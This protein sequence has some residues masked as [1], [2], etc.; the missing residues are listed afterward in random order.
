MI[1]RYTRPE[2]KEI[3]SEQ[4]KFQQ[5]LNV[6]IAVVNAWEARGVIPKT[7][8]ETI[9]KRANFSLERINEIEAEVH[10]DVI[11]FTTSVAEYVGESSRYF[12]YGLTS[13]DVV[14][15]A[16]AL[17]LKQA[18]EQILGDLDGL[19]EVCKEQAIRYKD[20]VMIGRTHGVH[21]EPITFGLKLALWYE[22]MKRNR[23][24]LLSAIKT[25]SYG[26]ISGAVGTYANIEPEIEKEVCLE[27]GLRPANISTQVLQRDRHA[28]Y[29][30]TLAIIASSLDKF[31]TEIRALQKTEVREVEEPFL[32][33]QKGSSAMP[34]KRNPITCERISGL[35]RVVR[36]YSQAALED[37]PLWHER[38][39]SHSSVERIILP[40]ATILLNYMLFQMTRIIR[41][42]EVYPE[43]MLR[44]LN[45][46]GGLI[47]SQ[48]ILLALVDKGMSR[49]AAYRKVQSLAMEAWQNLEE[50]KTFRELVMKDQE[51]REYLSIEEIKE[52]FAFDYHLRHVDKIFRKIGLGEERE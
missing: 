50:G 44:N 6:E 51:L 36:G 13:S 25:I 37:I 5:W 41:D 14:D 2:M 45:R 32:K 17:Q 48:R 16:L 33:G 12:H 18:S 29:V 21:A 8:A 38:D 30:S 9:R 4:N 34:H 42:L 15:T 23:E 26:K 7:E 27:L 43:N 10:H 46:T 22:E 24:R 28:E 3:W 19:L 35:A 47:F 1:E 20:T 52:S 40:D 39:I 11:A 31:A 49:E